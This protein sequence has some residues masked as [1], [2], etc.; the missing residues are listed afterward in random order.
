MLT[1]RA[2]HA[3]A[4]VLH[5]LAANA[6]KYGALSS[7][8]GRVE[9]KWAITPEGGF[10]LVWQERRGPPVSPPQRQGF[11]AMIL[12]RVAPREIDGSAEI[13]FRHEGVRAVLRAGYEALAE[14]PAEADDARA[15]RAESRR[16]EVSGGDA[17]ADIGGLK[18]LVVE[19]AGL[20]ALELEAALAEAGAKVVGPAASLDEAFGMLDQ[21]FDVVLL[22]SDLGGLSAAPVAQALSRRGAPFV[23]TAG[24]GEA[25]AEAFNAAATTVRKPYNVRQV[26]A[27]LARAGGR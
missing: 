26:A 7:D 18:I 11:G 22:D 5:E 12:E 16:Q 10:E 21:A 25:V 1:A 6:L 14:R 9:V 24:H 17:P 23:V 4:L 15:R 20:L 3:L 2:T 13:E 8:A 19:D 27:A